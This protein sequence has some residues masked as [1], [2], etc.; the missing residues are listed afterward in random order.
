MKQRIYDLSFLR[1]T[2]WDDDEGLRDDEIEAFQMTTH[3]LQSKQALLAEL[4]LKD[5]R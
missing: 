3:P 5:Q 4:P 1:L 2:I